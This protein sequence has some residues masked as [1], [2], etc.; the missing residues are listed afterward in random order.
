MNWL[1][2]VLLL[3]LLFM[4]VHQCREFSFLHEQIFM[5]VRMVDYAC[6]AYCL[7]CIYM[8]KGKIK[9]LLFCF[10]ADISIDPLTTIM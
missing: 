8:K 5:A 3:H 1:D 4:H 6:I 9:S 7:Q 2:F 10:R